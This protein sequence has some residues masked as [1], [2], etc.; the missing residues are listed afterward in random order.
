MNWRRMTF[1]RKHSWE[2][3]AIVQMRDDE[4]KLKK[5]QW[6]LNERYPQGLLNK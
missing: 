2:V 4:S 5:E 3:E 6:R 1:Y